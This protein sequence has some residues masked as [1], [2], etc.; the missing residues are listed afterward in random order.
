M[1]ENSYL[2]IRKQR[3]AF[4]QGIGRLRAAFLFSM[5]AKKRVTFYIDGFD[6]DD[7]GKYFSGLKV[8]YSLIDYVMAPPIN[9]EELLNKRKVKSNRIEFKASWIP[10]K[11]YHTM[12]VFATDLLI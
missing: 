12:C 7:L 6:F 11:I 3:P 4:L 2:C 1:R 10:D 5:E 8:F 9:I